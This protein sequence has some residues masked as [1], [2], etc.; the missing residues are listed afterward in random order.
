MAQT[1]A[2]REALIKAALQAN[3][4]TVDY[5]QFDNDNDG[6]IDYFAVLWTRSRQRLGQ[7]LVG[8]PDLVGRHPGDLSTA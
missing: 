3:D 6:K 1:Q 2:S 4:A 7:L 5:S 8:L